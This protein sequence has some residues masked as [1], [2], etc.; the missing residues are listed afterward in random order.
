MIRAR[1]DA[2]SAIR[3]ISGVVGNVENMRLGL[4]ETEQ[5]I[6]SYH[7]RQFESKGRTFKTPWK[8]RKVKGDGHPLMDDT[9]RLRN[10]LG[11]PSGNADS[12]R[13]VD[14]KGI[15]WGTRVP[16][17][18][19]HQEGRG[20][21]KRPVLGSNKTMQREVARVLRRYVVSR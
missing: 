1:V 20:V 8:A 11:S 21:P 5:I 17:A 18:Q 7:D 13:R 4:L 6:A 15:V 19:Y 2:S 12:V 16:Y 3:R 14:N 9:G 10:S